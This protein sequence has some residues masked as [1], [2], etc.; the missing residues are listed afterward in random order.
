LNLL[1]YTKIIQSITSVG[2]TSGVPETAASFSS[3]GFSNLFARPSYQ[4]SAVASY[5]STLG[6]TNAGL[7]NTSGRGF[8]DVAA[9]GQNVEIVFKG[10]TGGVAGTSCSSPIFAAIIGL[11]NDEL[12]AAGKNRLGFLNPLLYSSASAFNDITTGALHSIAGDVCF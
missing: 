1:S 5:L 3:G 6:S 12:V 10:Q 11:L 4:D 8:P 2:A 7:F 9:Q